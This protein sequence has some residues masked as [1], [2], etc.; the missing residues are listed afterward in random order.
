MVTR[1]LN[2]EILFFLVAVTLISSVPWT[3]MIST[4]HISTPFR[5]I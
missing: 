2:K 5:S 3:L 4:G 1:P